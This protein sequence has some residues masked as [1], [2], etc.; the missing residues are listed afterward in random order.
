MLIT[1]P[2]DLM[3]IPKASEQTTA[4]GRP[5]L[6]FGNNLRPCIDGSLRGGGANSAPE[7]ITDQLCL[8]DGVVKGKRS[9]MKMVPILIC[10]G[11]LIVRYM[12]F[13][14][15]ILCVSITGTVNRYNQSK[16]DGRV[17]GRAALKAS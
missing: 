2:F 12:V 13:N 9:L 1:K 17:K 5:G 3:D 8:M 11:K 15:M 7:S 6:G 16:Q 14:C 4:W 10:A